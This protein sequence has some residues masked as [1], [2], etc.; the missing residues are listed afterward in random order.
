M[1]ECTEKQFLADV[2]KHEMKVELNQG[3]HR[4]IR[5]QEPKNSNMWFEII[6]WPGSLTIHGDMGTWTFSRIDDMFGFFR[7]GLHDPGELKINPSYW[8][9]KLQ[10]G[11][12]GG[13]DSAREFSADLFK[14]E[15]LGRLDNWDLSPE[16][17]TEV[18]E[19]LEEEVFR[20]D[21]MHECYRALYQFNH[22]RVS[23]DCEMPDGKQYRYHYLW[24]LYAIVWAIQ[25]F[26]AAHA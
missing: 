15:V 16:E 18:V 25:Q 2:A 1:R 3:I 5:F 6:T 22:P 17:R 20:E 12:H 7:T 23:F 10:N 9:E 4:H 11:V 8:G 24:C 14:K 26:D 21:N 19:Q 13:S